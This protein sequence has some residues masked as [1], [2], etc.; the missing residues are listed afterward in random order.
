MPQSVRIAPSILAADFANLEAEIRAVS[1]AGAD[2]IHL[3]IMDGHYVPNLTF[4]PAVV[5]ALR[6]HSSLPFDAHL[7]ITPVDPFIEEFIKA[8]ADLVTIHPE[9]GSH[10]H[11]SLQLIKSFGKKAGVA[12][13]PATSLQSIEHVLD[14]IDQILVMTVNPGFGGQTFLDSQLPKIRTL[15]T[16]LDRQPRPIDLAV[17]GGITNSTAGQVVAAGANILIAGTAVFAGGKEKYQAN[18]AALKKSL[19]KAT[20]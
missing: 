4:G 19:M 20:L 5:K 15:R 9:S 2:L 7:M 6:S 3:D 16:L 18:I 14:I 17:D 8:G 1:M 11:R 10:L 13:N 12:L